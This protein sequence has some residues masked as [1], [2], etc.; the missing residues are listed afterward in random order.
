MQPIEAISDKNSVCNQTLP[1]NA[2]SR[3]KSAE[4]SELP[5]VGFWEFP[6]LV[7]SNLVVCIFY[8][9][10]LFCALLHPLALFCAL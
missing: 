2:S 9:E 6:N 10:A 4:I 7:V 3:R 8:A 1:G 5:G